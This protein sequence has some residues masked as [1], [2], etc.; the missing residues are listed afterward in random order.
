MKHVAWT[1]PL[2]GLGQLAVIILFWQA[3]VKF[4]DVPSLLLPG[5]GEV[6]EAFKS[7]RSSLVMHASM[8]FGATV[9]AFGFAA[10]IGILV[11][12]AMYY[13]AMFR[14]YVLPYIVGFQ[15]MPKVAF[16][17]LLLVWVGFGLRTVILVGVLVAVF[18]V[19]INTYAGLQ[20]VDRNLVD[21]ART[22]GASDS[23]LF[24]R[25]R[26]PYALPHVVS[27]LKTAMVLAVVGV[28][29]G[30][31]AGSNA[32]LGYVLLTATANFDTAYVFAALITLLV[33][34]I[35]LFFAVSRAE[36][37]FTWYQR[38]IAEIAAAGA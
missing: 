28:V 35:L 17:P 18:P 22:M 25:I 16:A 2:F 15:A 7:H 34:S 26:L 23:A 33:G 27:G 36:A 14:R 9:A 12:L 21:L 1:R 32:G 3:I 5:P 37:A 31:F 6:V 8:T 13:S 38:G 29:V 20:T 10:V 4:S 30:E 11:A 19:I 24:R